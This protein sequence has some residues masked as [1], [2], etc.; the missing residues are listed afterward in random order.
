MTESPVRAWAFGLTLLPFVLVSALSTGSKGFIVGALLS[1]AV[2]SWVLTGL[3]FRT[4]SIRDLERLMGFRK[5]QSTTF[6]IFV[7]C[8]SH[9]PIES[10]R[11]GSEICWR[12]KYVCAGCYGILIGAW[13]GATLAVLYLTGDLSEQGRV[14][15]AWLVPLC[16]VPI[17]L[18]YTLW[19]GLSSASRLAANA[20]LALGCWGMLLV[21]DGLF[22]RV[23]ANAV[24]LVALAGVMMLRAFAGRIDR[25]SIS[26]AGFSISK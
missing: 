14:L 16:F 8:H 11:G 18:R 21:V 10:C 6:W 24:A 15:G 9:H 17:I 4:R 7:L 25:R 5:S 3:R 13:L 20:A 19:R 26:G 22:V 23:L 2:M 1:T 12:G